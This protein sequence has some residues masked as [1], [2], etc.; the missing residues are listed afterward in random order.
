MSSILRAV[1][2]MTLRSSSR[3]PHQWLVI[4]DPNAQ[5][6]FDNLT[7]NEKRGNLRRLRELLI[8]N[9]PYVLPFVEM[10]KGKR[11]DRTRKFRVG[12]YRVFFSV[13]TQEVI[14]QSHTYKGTLF[15]LDIQQRK[16]AY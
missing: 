14:H 6:P 16:D 10:L 13:E 3:I 7:F 15:L 9:D 1:R 4:I 12:D 8:A 5:R 2:T 11:F